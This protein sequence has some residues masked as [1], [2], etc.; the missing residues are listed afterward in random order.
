MAGGGG[1]EGIM[2]NEKG[3]EGGLLAVGGSGDAGLLL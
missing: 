2:K 1:G 3:S